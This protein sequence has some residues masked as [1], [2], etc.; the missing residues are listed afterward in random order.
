[1][2]IFLSKKIAIPNG[3]KLKS[4]SWNTEE[5]W[6]ACGGE[7]G[8]LKVLKLETTEETSYKGIAAPTSL[9]MNQ[10]LEGH[11]GKESKFVVLI[12]SVCSQY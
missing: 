6:I 2:W 9:T 10:T 7:Q 11:K 1:M 8:L 4:I 3:V 5:G 12:T